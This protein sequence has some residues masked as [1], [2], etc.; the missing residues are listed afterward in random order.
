MDKRWVFPIVMPQRCASDQV[1]L[2][3]LSI[4]QSISWLDHL[5]I[6]STRRCICFGWHKPFL[7][8]TAGLHIGCKSKRWESWPVNSSREISGIHKLR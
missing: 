6:G 1:H 5:A 7:S 2:Q 3:L 8:F 4:N